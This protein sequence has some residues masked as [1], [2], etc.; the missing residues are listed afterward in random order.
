MTT[1]KTPIAY[2]VTTGSYSSYRVLGVFTTYKLARMAVAALDARRAPE[3]AAMADYLTRHGFSG[4]G[5]V[6]KQADRM[7]RGAQIE[8]YPLN[9]L[10]VTYD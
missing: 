3:V 7:V 2:V 10:E 5:D 4:R 8:R 6:M 1:P 9:P